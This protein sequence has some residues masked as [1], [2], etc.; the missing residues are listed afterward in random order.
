MFTQEWQIT[1]RLV[2]LGASNDYKLVI[3]RTVRPCLLSA[4]KTR[5][6]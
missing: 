1:H 3:A 2:G 4:P 6:N 5:G